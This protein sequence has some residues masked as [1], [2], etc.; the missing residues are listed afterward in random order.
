MLISVVVFL[1]GAHQVMAQ[2]DYEYSY[3]EYSDVTDGSGFLAGMGI[4][5]WVV[6]CCAMLIGLGSMIFRIVMLVHA[7]KNAPEDQKTLWILLLILVP[8]TP[9]I[10][11]FTKK[12]EW[13][14]KKEAKKVE[15][16]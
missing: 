9:F 1:A 14:P 2:W 11:F 8:L 10:Y 6:W 15:T 3:D 13:G 5:M 12:K 7:I 16:K 4:F